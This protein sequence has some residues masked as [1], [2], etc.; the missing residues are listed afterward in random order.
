MP[1]VDYLRTNPNP[2]RQTRAYPYPVMTSSLIIRRVIFCVKI[3]KDEMR[4]C[5]GVPG[6]AIR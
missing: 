2:Y 1:S 6:V 3:D 5:G 4:G